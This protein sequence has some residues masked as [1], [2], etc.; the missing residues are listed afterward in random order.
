MLEKLEDVPVLTEMPP[1]KPVSE[2]PVQSEVRFRSLMMRRCR[3]SAEV[4]GEK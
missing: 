3:A 4:Y 1:D 2:E